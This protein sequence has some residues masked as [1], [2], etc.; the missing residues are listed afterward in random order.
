VRKKRERKPRVPESEQTFGWENSTVMTPEREQERLDE[1]AKR[2]AEV[3][4]VMGGGEE[5]LKQLEEDTIVKSHEEAKKQ[6]VAEAHED[7]DG[8]AGNHYR[9]G[10]TKPAIKDKLV[11]FVYA[12]IE[13]PGEFIRDPKSVI[14]ERVPMSERL[15]DIFLRR[16]S[17]LHLE[18]KPLIYQ[19][20]SKWFSNFLATDIASYATEIIEDQAQ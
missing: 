10:K 14:L 5:A 18:K 2:D 6:E 13:A 8:Q 20:G 3:S 16:L 11:E 12:C 1:L 19:E 15:C 9:F 17:W 7:F 4:G